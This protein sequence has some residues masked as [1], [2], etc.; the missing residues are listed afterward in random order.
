MREMVM[1]EMVPLVEA[2]ISN[3]DGLR[4]LL[5]RN[6]RSRKLCLGH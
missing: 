5:A 2:Q 1:A 6:K 3:A 4:Y